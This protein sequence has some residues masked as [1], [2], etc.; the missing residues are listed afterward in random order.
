MSNVLDNR[1]YYK[2]FYLGTSALW[3]LLMIQS[4][5]ANAQISPVNIC[6]NTKNTFYLDCQDGNDNKTAWALLSLLERYPIPNEEKYVYVKQIVA[7]TN[8][9]LRTLNQRNNSFIQQQYVL[10]NSALIQD[11]DPSKILD[12]LDVIAA[13]EHQTE[14]LLQ[15]YKEIGTV[16]YLTKGGVKASI[17]A[18]R[19]VNELSPNDATALLITANLLFRTGSMFELDKVYQDAITLFEKQGNKIG[20]AASYY[21]LGL[22]FIESNDLEKAYDS[23]VTA[24]D[25]YRELD[26]T[27]G[28]ILS[29]TRLGTLSRAAYDFGQA[30]E[31]HKQALHLLESAPKNLNYEEYLNYFSLGLIYYETGEYTKAKELYFKAGRSS[32][33]SS[34]RD[35]QM[36]EISKQLG[37]VA[38]AQNNTEE[39]KQF[40]DTAMGL[41]QKTGNIPMVE[42]VK[43]LISSLP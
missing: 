25:L 31:R 5:N 21:N 33:F 8:R 17:A 3:C 30:M 16:A 7:V 42:E 26:N 2:Y 37:K 15:L 34:Y 41:Y 36:A 22:F 18:W 14:G 4:I 19:H 13:E 43:A 35:T 11:K 27:E 10:A 28:M 23:F 39:A 29:Y 24:N 40:L 32:V 1:S 12:L 9:I 20:I 38:N 6:T